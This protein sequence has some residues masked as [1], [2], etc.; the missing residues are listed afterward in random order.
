MPDVRR[1][2][3][4]LLIALLCA[5][6]STAATRAQDGGGQVDVFLE[7]I[8]EAGTARVYFV[9]AVSGL[10][11]IVR[12]DNGHRYTLVGNH[13]IYEKETSG[14]IMR[15]NADGTLE[16]HPFIRRGVSVRSVR[17]V[18]SPDREAL[19]W[20]LVDQEGRSEAFVSWADG[21]DLRQLPIPSP[22]LG[23][24]LSPLAITN[25]RT[26]FFY[27]EARPAGLADVPYQT[28]ASVTEYSISDEAFIPLPDEPLCPCGAALAADGHVLARLEAAQ[29]TGPF[30]LRVQDLSSGADLRILAPELPYRNA[31]DLLLNDSGALGVYSVAGGVGT[32]GDLLN[33]QYALVLVDTIAGQQYLVLPPGP[34]RYRPVAFWDDDNA[35]L[36]VAAND[37]S[38]HKLDLTSRELLRVS[39][40]TYLGTIT[41]AP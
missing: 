32:E 25:G 6:P 12:V 10:S 24:E 35:L 37:G 11:T 17:W 1:G 3:F 28:F 23:Y 38:T 14:A 33:E 15:A 36:L 34:V 19:A 8:A 13:V 30:A 27:D 41:S 22:S 40:L 21:G 31:G 2:L 26:R 9:D 4:A 5:L 20:V 16:P 29:G 7:V 18:V 39:D